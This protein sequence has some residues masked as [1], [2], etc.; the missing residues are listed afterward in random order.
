[1]RKNSLRKEANRYLQTTHGSPRSRTFRQYVIYHLVED[2]FV[3]G[4]VP[5]NWRAFN[6]IHL[7][8]LIQYWQ[9]K[10]MKPSTLLNRLTVIRN[11]L[12]K[13]SNQAV[14]MDN[15][16]L[17]ITRKITAKKFIKIEPY[18]WQKTDDRIA[19]IVLALE[20]HFGLTLSEALHLIPDIHIRQDALW[21]TREITFNSHDRVVPVR[22]E[23]QHV[24]LQE[25][26]NITKGDLSLSQSEGAATIRCNLH[27]SL[28]LL[29][30]PINK[31]W[32]Y[33]YAQQLYRELSPV[34]SH[35]QLTLLLMNEMGL[36]S[37]TSVW[38]NLHEQ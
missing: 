11:F 31:S 7:Q 20:V 25:L 14:T 21:L 23:T 10:K 37:R 12:Q 28:K 18:F 3:C 6:N 36:K 19:R 4:A 22:N 17:G 13:M 33:L 32:R 26:S 5:P 35:Y 2:L 29:K 16:S 24:I 30:L 38:R 34:L 27:R 1:M 9:K 8:Q 15:Q